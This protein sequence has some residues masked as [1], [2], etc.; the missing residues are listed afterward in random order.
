MVNKSYNP[1]K[2][3]GSYIGYVLGIIVPLL[4]QPESPFGKAVDWSVFILK[5]QIIAIPGFLA[6]WCIHS[7]IR[8]LRK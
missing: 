7:L 3:L 8:G 4:M 5:A 2:M 6:G 1:F